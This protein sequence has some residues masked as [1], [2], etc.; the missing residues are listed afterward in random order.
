MR[1]ERSEPLANRFLYQVVCQS[2]PVWYEYVKLGHCPD[3]VGI[4][5]GIEP[6]WLGILLRSYEIIVVKPRARIS[7]IPGHLSQK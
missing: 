4:R 3:E 2:N 5:Y 1:S 7:S 6:R